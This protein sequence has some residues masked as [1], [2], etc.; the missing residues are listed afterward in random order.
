MDRISQL[1][2]AL[3]L[4]KLSS[5]PSAKDV[6]ATMVLSKRW[7]FL[8]MLVPKLV[9]D[10]KYQNPEYAPVIETLHFKLGKTCGS[11][12]IR[13]WIKAADKCCVRELIIEIYSS[14]T[15]VT[16][17]RSLYSGGCRML[18][19]SLVSIKYPGDEFVKMLFSNCPVLEGLVVKRCLSDN[20]TIFTVRGGLCLKSLV[21]HSF[22]AA[23]MK[24]DCGFWIDAQSLE[25]LDIVDYSC[26]FCGI[27]NNMSKIVKADNAY[28]V[29]NVFHCLVRLTICTCEIEWLNLLMCC[30]PLR[31]N[32][33]RPSWNEPS[34]VPECVLTSL[35]TLEWVEYEDTEEERELA[36]FLLR[37]A[38]YLKKV[39]ISSK[40]TDR[41]EKFEMIKELSF[42]SRRSPTCHL[43]FA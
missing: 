15:P 4:K 29:G 32:E 33:P 12:D 11:G 2:D 17:P 30:H 36:A 37:S 19:L 43:T 31:D 16:I 38:N 23:K 9:F 8:W 24:V 10:D 28:P 27:E 26:G 35:E 21:L 40:S 34:A 3:L 39:T 13:V 20:V 7:Q 5:L 18:N 41:D 6:V 14:K 42:L 25:S 22:E 1:P